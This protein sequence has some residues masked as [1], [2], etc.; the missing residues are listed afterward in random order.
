[1]FSSWHVG[2]NQVI[3]G[4]SV[5]LVVFAWNFGWMGQLDRLGEKYRRDFAP[6]MLDGER[7]MAQMRG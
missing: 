4:P 3:L 2:A 5:L 7:G 6:A 1:M